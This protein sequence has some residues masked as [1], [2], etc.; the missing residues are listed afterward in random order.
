MKT[1]LYRF[2]EGSLIWTLTSGDTVVTYGGETYI[3]E[4]LGRSEIEQKTELPKANIEISFDL[5]SPV[6]R[7]WMIDKVE[8]VVTITVFELDTGNTDVT[9]AWKGRMVSVKPTE[10]EIKVNFESI[11]T[12]L[13][14]PG[15]A[16]RYLRTCRYSLYGRGCF[17]DQE[18]FAIPGTVS[19]VNGADVTVS[20]AAG[21]ADG[22]FATGMIKAPDGT[23]RFIRTHVGS[24]LNLIRALPLAN[25][26]LVTLYPGCDRLRS[27][28]NDKFNNLNNY[29][30]FD[31][32][33]TR[34]PFD[35][36]SIV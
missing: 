28:C 14:R 30:G 24:A 20:A 9:V 29:G 32:I 22:Y 18:G 7:R 4:P 36:S 17:L 34:N 16:P 3:P 33:P 25:G 8:Q 13:R 21:Y 19:A 6:A 15:L 23:L 26:N 10:S 1:E 2:V 27:T 35:G 11:F 31:W 12:S 5:D